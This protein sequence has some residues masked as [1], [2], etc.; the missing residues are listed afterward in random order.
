MSAER[1]EL[2]LVLVGDGSTGKS[3]Y[4]ARLSREG[5]LEDYVATMGYEKTPV[6]VDTNV[7]QF[8]V[9]FWDTAGQE[10]AGPLRDA[11]YEGAHGAILFFDVTSRVTY[12][13]VP[14]WHRDLTRVC[15]E[16]P[17]VL[18]ANKV[19]VKERKVKS[20]SIKYQEKY[21]SMKLVEA[22]IKDRINLKSPIEFLLQNITKNNGLEISSSL[23][24]SLFEAFENMEFAHQNQTNFAELPTSE[25]AI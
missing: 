11:Y 21:C 7:G 9:M 23:E 25:E 16:I 3:S 10:K 8:N 12:K 17:V 20:K 15:G 5:F 18:L 24:S 19:D 4:I 6:L 14:T 22:S 13:N 2:K 1:Q